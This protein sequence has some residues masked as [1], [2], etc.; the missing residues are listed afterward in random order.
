MLKF[1]FKGLLMIKFILFYFIFILNIHALNLGNFLIENN[2]KLSHELSLDIK[3]LLSEYDISINIKENNN[4]S[5]NIDKLINNNDTNFFALVNKDSIEYFNANYND[6]YK[7]NSIYKKIPA[8][9][10]LGSEQ[11]HIFANENKLFDFELNKKYKV[12]CGSKNS[13]SCISTYNIEKSYGFDFTYID[14]KEDEIFKSLS[15]GNIDLYFY[16]G[17]APVKKFKDLNGVTL[18]DLPT[19]FVME[20]TYINNKISAD[21]YLFLNDD[22][23]TFSSPKV[24]IT[25]LKDSKYNIVIKDL[26]KIILLN[27][28][29]LNKKNILWNNIDFEYFEFKA[30][31]KI[32]KKNINK[33][34]QEIKQSNA[35]VF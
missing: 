9:L 15:K 7:T 24:L 20:N 19:N 6:D 5:I 13:S 35:L 32:S 27:K 26:I 31:S 10:A 33:L 11:I 8:I 25:T 17:V 30:F 16:V 14:I 22:I 4:S 1:H 12:Y 3:N 34:T 18:L 21:D 23:H 28:S 29:Y 2:N